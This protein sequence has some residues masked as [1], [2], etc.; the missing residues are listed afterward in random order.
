MPIKYNILERKIQ[1]ENQIYGVERAKKREKI[2]FL[3]VYY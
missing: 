2:K 3:A 1:V